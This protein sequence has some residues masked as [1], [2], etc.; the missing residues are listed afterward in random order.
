MDTDLVGRNN[1]SIVCTVGP[2][3]CYAVQ[4]IYSKISMC[5]GTE[6][7]IKIDNYPI[8]VR[9]KVKFRVRGRDK[10]MGRFCFKREIFN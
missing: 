5:K 7:H 4:R 6:R 1:S 2:H 9:V 10:V 8:W 3:F